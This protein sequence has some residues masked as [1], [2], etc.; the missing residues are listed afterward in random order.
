MIIKVFKTKETDN[1]FA[2]NYP[3]EFE[4]MA[5]IPEV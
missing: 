5:L 4:T 2:D 1:K 3:K